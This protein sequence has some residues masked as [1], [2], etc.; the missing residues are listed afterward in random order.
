MAPTSLN[1]FKANCF[2]PKPLSM[3]R[4][5]DVETDGQSHRCRPRF[6]RLKRK[7]S[8]TLRLS[9]SAKEMPSA[10][11]ASAPI[12]RARSSP[13]NDERRFGTVF[14]DNSPHFLPHDFTDD[15]QS[16]NENAHTEPVG[17]EDFQF[18]VT[19]PS[20]ATRISQAYGPEDLIPRENLGP[21][22]AHRVSHGRSISGAS[23]TSSAF[24]APSVQDFGLTL[25]RQQAR[26]FLEKEEALNFERGQL[27]L[28]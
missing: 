7:L 6:P 14:L 27:F 28:S 15:D 8:K 11:H 19:S 26:V 21:W 3:S 4:S 16:G 12:P 24:T 22:T 13:Y 20:T 2:S 25:P 10:P 5:R 23:T 9:H 18:I 17:H 1:L